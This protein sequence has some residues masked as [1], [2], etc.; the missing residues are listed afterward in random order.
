MGGGVGGLAAAL[1]LR[2]AKVDAVVVERAAALERVGYGIALSP[3]AMLALDALGVGDAVRA[4][5]RAPTGSS[6]VHG[7][8]AR[9]AR[10]R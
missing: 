10:S 2:R 4:H 9:L 7:T 6:S 3:N 5:G 8:V 1:A